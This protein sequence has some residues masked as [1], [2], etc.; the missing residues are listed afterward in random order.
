MALTTGATEETQ[1]RYELDDP[2]HAQLITYIK[3][4]GSRLGYL[5]NFNEKLI[6]NGIHRFVL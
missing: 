4:N 2:N 5:V 1:G 3:I 6:K